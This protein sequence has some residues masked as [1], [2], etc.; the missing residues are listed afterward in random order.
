MLA[1]HHEWMK[2][3]VIHPE[4]LTL[5]AGPLAQRRSLSP[6]PSIASDISIS[7]DISISFNLLVFVHNFPFSPASVLKLLRKANP[8]FLRG[9]FLLPPFFLVRIGFQG[10]QLECLCNFGH[11][12]FVFLGI[13]AAWSGSNGMCWLKIAGR[14]LA[15]G[16]ILVRILYHLCLGSLRVR[17]SWENLGF[18]GICSN[19]LF[20][21]SRFPAWMSLQ[22]WPLCFWFSWDLRCILEWK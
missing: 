3:E 19:S 13:C 21:L 8:T 18:W 14:L 7:L 15:L 5:S 16:C 4:L 12:V 17:D 2:M 10:L 9:T 20:F 11:F 1:P 22:F 6:S